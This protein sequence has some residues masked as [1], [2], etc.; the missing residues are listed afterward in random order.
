MGKTK[1]R[2]SMELIS[3]AEPLIEYIRKNEEALTTAI[4]TGTGVEILSVEKVAAYEKQ[5][6]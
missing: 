5:W 6:D 4:V 2:D 1:S 3:A